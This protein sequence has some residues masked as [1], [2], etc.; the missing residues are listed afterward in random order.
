MIM[1]AATNQAALIH[2]DPSHRT[3]ACTCYRSAQQRCSCLG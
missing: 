2:L 1:P 3:L